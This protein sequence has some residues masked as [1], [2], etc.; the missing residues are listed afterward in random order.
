MKSGIEN[1]A[2]AGLGLELVAVEKQAGTGV[3]SD[4]KVDDSAAYVQI[5]KKGSSESL[6]TYLVSLV[7]SQFGESRERAGMSSA[8]LRA[9]YRV[10]PFVLKMS[11]PTTVSVDGKPYQLAL[12][13][14]RT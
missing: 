5:L 1:P 3:S 12:R 7:Q 2:T 13:F 8:E 10:G 4:S 9:R 11:E 6:G 14:K